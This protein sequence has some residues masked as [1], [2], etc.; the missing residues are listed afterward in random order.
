MLRQFIRHGGQW[1]A[2]ELCI[3]EQERPPLI[4]I[5]EYRVRHYQ[6]SEN[7]LSAPLPQAEKE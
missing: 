5:P 6:T 7:P 1:Q 2:E 3:V 4:G